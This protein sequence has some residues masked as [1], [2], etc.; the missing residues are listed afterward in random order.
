MYKKILFW[1]VGFSQ[2]TGLKP[3]VRETCA[4]LEPACEASPCCS[5]RLAV[6][7]SMGCR[8]RRHCTVEP[9]EGEKARLTGPC[10]TIIM[11]MGEKKKK[12]LIHL[13]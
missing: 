13:L 3:L 7:I 4:L 11:K 8:A 5:H 12:K 2:S 6:N 1:Q 10:S 9:S